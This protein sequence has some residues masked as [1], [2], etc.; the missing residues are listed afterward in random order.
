M[1]QSF[2][3]W[4]CQGAALQSFRWIFKMFSPNYK[5]KFVALCEPRISG[6][7]AYDFIRYSRYEHSHRV[8]ATGFSGGIW[9][10]WKARLDVTIL[11]NHKQS[12]HL[13][14]LD[15]RGLITWV[16]AIYASLVSSLRNSLWNDLNYLAE[17]IQGLWML[18]GDFNA[19]LS[20]SE[21][22]W[23]TNNRSQP[24]KNFKIGSIN[25]ASA[26]SII[27]DQNL[28]GKGD[29]FINAWIEP[30]VMIDDSTLLTRRESFI[31]QDWGLT[32]G[33]SSLVWIMR[34]LKTEGWN[35]FYSL[36]LGLLISGSRVLFLRC[37]RKMWIIMFR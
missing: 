26:T 12:I 4:N 35:L 8:E 31:Y 15:T 6:V 20:I 25:T 34:V 32:I 18:A 22:K 28:L 21:C 29:H 33:L 11:I 23:S 36:L 27:Q 17:T 5:P 37:G 16:T 30:F 24:Y 19:I 10:L 3:F 1:N 13:Q 14:V 7:K 9:L 2:L